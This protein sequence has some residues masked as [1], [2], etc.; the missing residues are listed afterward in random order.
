[1]RMNFIIISISSIVIIGIIS[2]LTS[3]QKTEH[4]VQ[5][6]SEINFAK[7]FQIYKNST[8][9]ILVDS[10][11]RKFDSDL[12]K[13]PVNRMVLFSST[14]AAFLDRLN[15]TEK[16]V[17]IAWAG[18]YD[19]YITS[20][21]NGFEEKTITDIGTANNPNYDVITSL[22]PDLVLLVGGTG[23]WETHAKKLDELGINYVVVSE[24]MEKDSIGKFEWIRFFGFLTGVYNSGTEIFED[25]KRNVENILQKTKNDKKPNFLWGGVFNGIAFVPRTDTYAANAI[26]D[27]NANNAFSDLNGTGSAQISLEELL[28]RGKNSQIMVYTGGFINNTNQITSQ[29]PILAKL[30]PI[31]ECNVYSFEPWYWQQADEYSAFMTDMAAIVHPEEFSDYQLQLFKKAECS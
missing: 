23:M 13:I 28:V 5:N 2:L 7:H 26:S 14:H 22:E 29:Y 4:V 12:L 8:E 20:I 19:W 9:Y 10:A 18:S 15:Q 16:I 17:G 30:R 11:Q 6:E 27:V 1:M 31:Q 21:K 24:W 3:E 25:S